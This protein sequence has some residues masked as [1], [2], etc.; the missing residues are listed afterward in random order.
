MRVHGGAVDVT[1]AAP[2]FAAGSGVVLGS[3][4][5]CDVAVAG[6]ES[7]HAVLFWSDTSLF[8]E[9]LS[10]SGTA[11]DGS[12]IRP[13]VRYSVKSGSAVKLGPAAELRL[14]FTPPP[15]SFGQA[16]LSQAFRSL[17]AGASPEVKR[18]LDTMN[19]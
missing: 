12:T 15:P 17:A 3:G 13:G 4:S 7:A 19:E 8:L 11:L 10:V 9:D 14:E 2:R 6:A 1:V 18:L 5:G 16:V